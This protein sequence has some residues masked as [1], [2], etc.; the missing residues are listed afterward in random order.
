MLI[1]GDWYRGGENLGYGY[2]DSIIVMNGWYNS[3]GHKDNLLY[4]DW[5]YHGVGVV[6]T[7]S[8]K[9]YATQNFTEEW[10]R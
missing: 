9:L 2:F 6:N 3:E 10:N 4:R 8:N 5:K 7:Q 1:S